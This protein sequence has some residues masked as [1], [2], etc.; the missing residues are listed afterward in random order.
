[1][2][3]CVSSS[4]GGDEVAPGLMNPLTCQDTHIV[5]ALHSTRQLGEGGEVWGVEGG[6][7]RYGGAR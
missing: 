6:E 4:P 2:L 7:V 5:G 1:M 3:V